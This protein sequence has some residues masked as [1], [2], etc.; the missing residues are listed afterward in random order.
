MATRLLLR[1]RTQPYG[2]RGVYIYIWLS[3]NKFQVLFSYGHSSPIRSNL[4]RLQC[5]C[6]T[7]P[8]TYGRS[9]ESPLVWA[10]QW[11]SSQP[12]SS[13]QLSHNIKDCI[14]EI[15][16]LWQSAFNR[17]YSN[18]C[19]SCSFEPKIIKISQSSHKMYSNNILNFQESTTI[20]NAC[21]KKVRKLI[22]GTTYILRIEMQEI[23]YIKDWN[24]RN[25]TNQ[26]K[27]FK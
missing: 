4:L 1:Q 22:E 18:S 15:H 8:T 9:H 26:P 20:L 6:C 11:P 14:F 7:V 19:C 16:Q 23:V 3:L 2:G 21:T 5:T 27:S 25:P 10:C 12:L 24:A 17:V 13:P